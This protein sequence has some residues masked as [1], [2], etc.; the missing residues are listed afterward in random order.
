MKNTI[1]AKELLLKLDNE[2][3]LVIIDC[4]FDLI[5]RDYGIK[6]Y[7]KGHIKGSFL[8]DID[9]DLSSSVQK[10]GGKN[11]L[12]DPSVL[13]EKLEKMGIDNNTI[14]VI[15][16][17]G[18]LN[19]AC[20]LFFQIKHL[21]IDNVVVLDGGI[22]SFTHNGGTLEEKINIP[23]ST[24]KK[25]NMKINNNLIASID[26]VKSKLYNPDTIIIDCRENRRYQGIIEPAYS[27]AGHIPSAKNYYF[28]DLLKDNFKDGS[29][30]DISFLRSFFLK[31]EN[32]KEVIL[33]CGSGVSACV[34]SLVLRE[35]GI[36]HKV[37]IG[38]FSD[39]ISYDSNSIK[40][41]EE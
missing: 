21:G 22:A 7:K 17:D 5:D 11:P 20:R 35:L 33:Y 23:S 32:Y 13:K 30:K 15:Y 25:I 1:S 31:L 6:A 3:N 40:T 18:D 10:H 28:K 37:Y 16:D 9:K 29:F 24:S 19:G 38:S 27:K 36:E 14:V 12:Q 26:Y 8:L 41:G 39:W 4:R 34:N 2:D